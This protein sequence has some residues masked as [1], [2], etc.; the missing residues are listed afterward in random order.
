[1]HTD[2]TGEM[3]SL[4]RNNTTAGEINPTISLVCSAPVDT[5]SKVLT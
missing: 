1:M 4:M 3:Y 2:V 5:V